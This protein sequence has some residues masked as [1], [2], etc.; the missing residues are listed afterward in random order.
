MDT[1]TRTSTA[2]TIMRIGPVMFE[3][4]LFPVP[5]DPP[6][7]EKGDPETRTPETPVGRGRV[8]LAA[9]KEVAAPR[10]TMATMSARAAAGADSLSNVVIRAWGNLT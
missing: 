6:D 4:E 5:F 2:S 1:T 7:E 3:N 8:G 10:A 9:P